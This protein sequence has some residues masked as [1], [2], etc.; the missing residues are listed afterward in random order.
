M[1]F[2]RNVSTTLDPI[3]DISL[4]LGELVHGG[5]QA[6]SDDIKT[7]ED[8]LDRLLMNKTGIIAA[9]SVS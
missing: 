7:L 2:F 3:W 1:A 5:P 4:D 8:C 6:G 9:F